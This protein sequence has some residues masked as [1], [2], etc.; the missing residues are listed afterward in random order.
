ME[1][2]ENFNQEE[3]KTLMNIHWFSLCA[4]VISFLSVGA[5]AVVNIQN[6]GAGARSAAGQ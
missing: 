1:R 3:A 5:E 2:I 4:V 6:V